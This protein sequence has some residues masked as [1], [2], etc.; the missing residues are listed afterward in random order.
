M[1]TFDDLAGQR[2]L[3]AVGPS[4]TAPEVECPVDPVLVAAAKSIIKAQ[5]LARAAAT[6]AAEGADAS[7][8]AA[9]AEVAPK[10]TPI[11]SWVWGVSLAPAAAC[12]D[13]IAISYTGSGK[14]LAF[15]VPV[16]TVAATL[17]PPCHSAGSGA[18][19]ASKAAGK[20]A[21]TAVF[22]ARVK[23]GCTKDDAKEAAKVAFVQAAKA[24]AEASS[25]VG[26]VLPCAVVLAPTRE[27]CQQT[28]QVFD[29]LLA[30]MRAPALGGS[31]EAR[32]GTLQPAVA[33]VRCMCIIGGVSFDE[34]RAQIKRERPSVIAATPGRMVSLC[35][36]TPTSAKR[37]RDDPGQAGDVSGMDAPASFSLA[38][39]A[40]FVL[41]EAD[42]LLDL[43]FEADIRFLS[44]CIARHPRTMLLS[45]T[46]AS[47]V[48]RLA[49]TL[50]DG[51]AVQIRV[52][53]VG[54]HTAR[55][56]TQV[57]E[58]HRGK[59]AP[60]FRRLCLLLEE[61]GCAD[62]D[63]GGARA[64]AGEVSSATTPSDD[65]AAV[66]DED[67]AAVDM[68][69]GSDG[70]AGG[71]AAVHGRRGAVKII[72]FVLYKKEARDIAKALAE[73]GFV[74]R[75]LHGD[76]SQTQRKATMTSF[77]SSD[78]PILVATDVA[79]RGLDVTGITHV[80]NF[81]LGLSI[82][83]YV[84]R[85]G[86]CGRAGAK[87]TAFSFVTDKD[88]HMA[89]K[90]VDVLK[91]AHQPV[92]ADLAEMHARYLQKSSNENDLNMLTEDAVLLLEQRELNQARQ[93][94]L[95]QSKSKGQKAQSGRRGKR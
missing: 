62:V 72:V 44:S 81:S 46:W 50:L 24:H 32:D 58:V 55:N 28:A 57:V 27:L 95:R 9:V 71:E 52:G 19:D 73:K 64:I 79:A 78:L 61:C 67:N 6:A 8:A 93:L 16:L 21:A 86:R 94:Q 48:E 29:S 74:A 70:E 5:C 3:H 41:D 30:E 31:G 22:I 60:R 49:T 47:N 34:Q 90:L 88:I 38:N 85:I 42:R 69:G 76:M 66:G 12:T 63:T 14:T 87:G 54:L 53:G 11:Q 68:V 40:V 56:V 35:G 20:T 83:N 10:P 89:G 26:P 39:V 75:A 25:S 77:K 92:P 84:H 43:G 37:G 15:A 1:H 45:A 2:V 18:S 36:G 91:A 17:A 4:G 82:D 65:A 13:L 33:L 51:S 80:I 23:A 7:A 59:G